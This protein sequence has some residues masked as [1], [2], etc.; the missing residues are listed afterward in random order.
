MT[1][2]EDREASPGGGGGELF[3]QKMKR[4]ANSLSCGARL[5]KGSEN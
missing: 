5:F 4:Q 2:P 1:L 3:S